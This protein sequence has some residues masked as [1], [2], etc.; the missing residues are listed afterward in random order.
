MTAERPG[1]H[2][3]AACLADLLDSPRPTLEQAKIIESPLD[4]AVVIA[5]A[6]SGKTAVIAQRVVWL[7]AN[8]LVDADRILGLTFTRKA[9]GELSER[10]RGLLARYRRATG[11]DRRADA[12]PGLDVPTVSTYNSYASALAADYGMEVGLDDGG[13]V[14]DAA[15][16]IGLVGEILDSASVAEV[17]AGRARSGLITAV[18]E[19]ADGMGDHL[20]TSAD[21]IAFLD[22]TAEAT[23]VPE[24]LRET[25]KG[26]KKKAGRTAEEAAAL[27]DELRAAADLLAAADRGELAE[28]RRRA[29]EALTG[30]DSAL[31]PSLADKRL[32]AGLAQRYAAEKAER[33][34]ADF[35][36]QVAAAHRIMTTSA[37]ARDAERSR[38][39]VILLDEYQD[40]SYAQ[41]AMLGALFADR[42]VMAVGDPRQAIYGWRGASA[43]NIA[44]FPAAFPGPSGRPAD[45]YGLSVS[46]RN[47][48]TV[49][50]AANRIAADLE[51]GAGGDPLR[52]RAAAVP[53]QTSEHCCAHG[54]TR[55]VEASAP[56]AE[57]GRVDIV[58][59]VD[60]I[61]R[62]EEKSET[63]VIT[64][65]ISAVREED[66]SASCAVLCRRRSEFEPIS[67]AL[68][69]AG[70][71]VHI[72]GSSG[73][74][75]D[76]FVADLVAALTVLADP[77]AAD[78]LM[79][80]LSGRTVRLGA[81]DLRALSRF[82][83][84]RTQ[85]QSELFAAG[86]VTAADAEAVGPEASETGGPGAGGAAPA[87][88][89]LVEAIDEALTLAEARE[90]GE[91]AAW[92]RLRRS[93]TAEG[94]RRVVGLARTLRRHR[95]EPKPVLSAVRDVIVGLGLDAE[96]AALSDAEA[97][98]RAA[99]LDAFV[100]MVAGFAGERP[101]GDLRA[102]IDWLI[103]MRE[104]DRTAGP[105]PVEEEG[106]VVLMTIHASKGLE[107]DAVVVP[108][109]RSSGLPAPL[110]SKS[111]WLA[112]SAV[113][114]PL[115]GDRA[116]LPVFDPRTHGCAS[117]KEVKAELD[118]PFKEA[119]EDRQLMEERRLAYVAVTRARTRLL[120]TSAARTHRANLHDPSPFLLEAAE[121]L[122]VEV[123]DVDVQELD[124]GDAGASAPLWPRL[125]PEE[126]VARRAEI[127]AAVTRA[128]GA[129]LGSLVESSPHPRIRALAARAIA[130]AAER[131]DAGHAESLP[132]RVSATGLVSATADR[133]AWESAL[134]RP[135][136]QPPN[137]AAGLGVAFHAWVEQ[138][139]GQSALLDPD[140]LPAGLP[141][142][143][144]ARFE[145]LRDTFLASAYAHLSPVA[146]ELSFELA[147]RRP[148]GTPLTVPGMVDAVFDDGDGGLRIVDWKTGRKPDATTLA[149]MEVQLAVYRS[150]LERIPEFAGARRI[151]AEF[152][153][154]GSDEVWRPEALPGVE[155]IITVLG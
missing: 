146:V 124:A 24:Y 74:L 100:S 133:Q 34:L 39:D 10:V 77:Q 57:E 135:M 29:L 114:Y 105:E 7:V 88:V 93:M 2:I 45:R 144:G 145:E 48:E 26:V 32:I 153:F 76:P 35:S 80:L 119:L 33:G 84:E 91:D 142:G 113:P 118:G 6:G 30:A 138:H 27:R 40:T 134:L 82:A 59:V 38:W 148:D 58:R 155:E 131:T 13:R 107:F 54:S 116:A 51:D 95:A 3:C 98:V 106:A 73:V 125:S 65:W 11:E 102:L 22:E 19:L 87:P 8:G 16:R 117:P 143:L 96:T 66:P 5:G 14:L 50:A 61:P 86:A 140:E 55:D 20:L 53:A 126:V 62:S 132:E 69:D 141:H 97:E 47:S 150:A 1:P 63:A 128:H 92:V 46:W 42:P 72:V 41:Y 101:E 112:L 68:E 44:N 122:G 60:D 123:P 109:L 12:L 21:V 120:L 129:D 15:G 43:D 81:S 127:I 71:P 79:R 18:L 4:S 147:L 110:R 9:V 130:L 17:P 137:P 111:G 67:T 23:A 152:Y 104:E 28:L 75:D 56:D 36:D 103:V 139:Y 52:T 94:L 90:S 136:P 108:G 115:R 121:A 99:A 89:G 37:M 70:F 83:R 25:A 149:A 49:L 154:V 64:E 151:S 31:L 85:A 78:A